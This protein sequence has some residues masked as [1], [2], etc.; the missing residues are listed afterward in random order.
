MRYTTS[1]SVTA[2]SDVGRLWRPEETRLFRCAGNA[3]TLTAYMCRAT[4]A[5]HRLRD[6]LARAL[7]V[8]RMAEDHQSGLTRLTGSIAGSV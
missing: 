5:R 6:N 8:G 7:G 1:Y 2:R 3:R 4:R